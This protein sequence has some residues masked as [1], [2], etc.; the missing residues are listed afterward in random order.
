MNTYKKYLERPKARLPEKHQEILDQK[1][2]LS[3]DEV[4][5]RAEVNRLF[6]K[7]YLDGESG[8]FRNPDGSSYVAALIQMPRVRLEM[9][10]WWF[11]WHAAEPLRYQIWYPDRHFDISAD[12]GG[13]YEDESKSYRERLHL[14]QHLVTEDIGQGK[15]KILI[16]FCPPQDF[17]F[18]QNRL[19]ALDDHT[20]ICAQVGSPS[21]G[22]WMVDM[23]HFVRKTEEGVEMRSRFWIGQ[24]IAR[25]PS[26][27]RGLL[28]S[29]LNQA[30]VKKNLIP[31]STGRDLFYHC[32]QEYHNLAAF[33]PELYA[34]QTGSG[35]E[36]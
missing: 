19:K 33:L 28:N 20:I 21:R 24:Q 8:Y 34:S 32:S 22:V 1:T 35:V 25:M 27:A 2:E 14:S 7:G 29:L 4:L 26:F 31:K 6:E 18:D 11:W 23:C 3:S 16:N 13:Y 12:F 9:I 17:G 15:E 5:P 30:W 36:V 10:D